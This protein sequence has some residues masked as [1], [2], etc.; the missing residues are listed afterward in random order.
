MV[1]TT[2][3][4]RADAFRDTLFRKPVEQYRVHRLRRRTF[5]RTFAELQ[6]LS[7]RDLEDIGIARERIRTIAREASSRV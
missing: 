4:N 2:F 1:D 6:A 3:T 7:D 5:G